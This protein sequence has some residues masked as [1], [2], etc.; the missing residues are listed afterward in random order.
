MPVKSETQETEI[1]LG[2]IGQIWTCLSILNGWEWH[3][4][5]TNLRSTQ[6]I[7]VCLTRKYTRCTFTFASKTQTHG[8]STYSFKFDE[9]L[10]LPTGNNLWNWDE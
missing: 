2:D 6:Y 1:R 9:Y 4:D 7:L 8:I 5:Q 3:V 10:I